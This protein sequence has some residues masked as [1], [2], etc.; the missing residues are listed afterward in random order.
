M[1][2]EIGNHEIDFDEFCDV[3]KRLNA[4]K[5]S[6]NEVVR[7]C[8][9][10]FDRSESGAVSKKDFEFILREVGDITDNAI[11]DEIFDEVDVDGDGII[12]Y[13][14]FTFMVRNYMT[15]DDIGT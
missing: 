14:E 10:V 6:W 3:M 13:D 15:D 12:D 4:K 11:I 1:F 2:P 9:T 8:F 5:R 7:E